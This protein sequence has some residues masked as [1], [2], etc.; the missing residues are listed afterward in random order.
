[1][2]IWDTSRKLLASSVVNHL[3]EDLTLSE[4]NEGAGEATLRGVLTR[5]E[6]IA[7]LGLAQVIAGDARLTIR[8]SDAPT[9]LGRGVTVTSERAEV[10]R[11][12][13]VQDNGETLL[14]V[15]LC[16]SS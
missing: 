6:E 15:I 7:R 11:V 10:F 16:R 8:V 3:G 4:A 12:T 2:G 13:A 9:W 14:E 1:V 5:P